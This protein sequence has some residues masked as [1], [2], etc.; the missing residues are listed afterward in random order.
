[1]S[2]YE[3]MGYIDG[4]TGIMIRMKNNI[5]YMNGYRRGLQAYIRTRIV[6]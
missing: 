3:T 4:S 6:D 1:M 5:D 2:R